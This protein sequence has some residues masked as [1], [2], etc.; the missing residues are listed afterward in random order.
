MSSARQS[1]IHVKGM[2]YEMDQKRRA[3]W[4][5]ICYEEEDEALSKS[6]K[7]WKLEERPMFV[8]CTYNCA[9]DASGA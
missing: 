3:Y 1:F 9:Y 2:E 4:R 7:K 8:K 6:E 5:R